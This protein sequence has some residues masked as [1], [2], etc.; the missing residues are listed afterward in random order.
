MVYLIT[1]GSGFYKIGVAKRLK[2]RIATLQIG[3]PRELIAVKTIYFDS[4]D[5][6][7]RAERAFHDEYNDFRAIKEKQRSEWFA[8]NGIMELIEANSE[9]L[10]R[11]LEKH[12]LAIPPWEIDIEDPRKIKTPIER[13]RKYL[14]TKTYCILL[15][16]GFA[17]VE[18]VERCIE[19][20]RGIRGIGW[21]RWTYIVNSI[22]DLRNE[23]RGG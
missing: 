14:D 20:Q 23:E 19:R 3:N 1:D 10:S 18:A 13:L 12:N 15:E 4:I 22:E 9:D 6:D 8:E 7:Y 2:E 16:N 11:I 17:T 5:E 21:K